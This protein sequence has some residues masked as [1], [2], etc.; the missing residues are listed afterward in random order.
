MLNDQVPAKKD[1]ED[2]NIIL[3][4]GLF[5][6]LL[7]FF[8]VLNSISTI[9]EE[10]TYVVLTSVS[11][12]FGWEGSAGRELNPPATVEGKFLSPEEFHEKVADL[13]K[14][15]FP[16]AQVKIITPDRLM[17]IS[18]PPESLFVADEPRLRS[19][20]VTILGDIADALG[21]SP[22]GVRYETEAVVAGPWIT[23][24]ELAQ[25]ETL[26]IARSGAL[27]AELAAA[28][29]PP[30]TVVAGVDHDESGEVRLRF[31]VRS[32]DEPRVDFRNLVR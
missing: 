11:L 19:D 5:L 2:K 4:L 23:G 31:Y 14:T 7:A 22:L 28:G 16:F 24:R 27:A 3:F 18:M 9:V 10:K 26:E 1:V 12:T 17:Q 21:R 13:V 6:L 8:I 32:E 30:G 20:A 25:G 29:A 15:A